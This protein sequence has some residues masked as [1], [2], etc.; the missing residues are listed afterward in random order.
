MS[1]VSAQ[2]EKETPSQKMK[3]AV[4]Q[5]RKAP[6][7]AG[8][9]MEG[10]IE[11]GKAK[12]Q[13]SLGG[14]APAK[15]AETNNL[16]LPTKRPE[17]TAAPR[18]STTGKRDPF[19]PFGLKTGTTRRIREGASPLERKDLGQFKLVGIIWDMKEPK[20]MVEDTDG[21]GYTIKVGTSIGDKDGKV[22]A[23]GPTEVV[24]E[25]TDIDFY[26]ARKRRERAIRM[27]TEQ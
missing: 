8:N 10:L 19:R 12:L 23:I 14:D 5:L 26:G 20:A 16:D 25:E 1:S 4:D 22:K 9:A 2:E 15:K 18:Y 21:L 13:G 6:A 27:P 7:V 24:V 3:E 17:Q 11:A